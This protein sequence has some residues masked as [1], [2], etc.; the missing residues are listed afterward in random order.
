MATRLAVARMPWLWN[1]EARDQVERE[2]FEI[3]QRTG[4]LGSDTT[5]RW[6]EVLDNWDH[7]FAE[8]R[9]IAAF[10]T[11]LIHQDL[12]SLRDRVTDDGIPAGTLLWQ[13]PKLGF[14]A[15]AQPA[16]RRSQVDQSVSVLTLRSQSRDTRLSTPFLLPFRSLLPVAAT[17]APALFSQ[18]HAEALG[19]FANR[20][21]R[22]WTRAR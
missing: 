9:A 1:L 20:I 14:C 17:I 21:E 7:L 11:A 6:Q 16:K 22:L 5:A 2:L 13:G 19:S 18:A 12:S 15:L 3:A 4:W 10:E 8:G